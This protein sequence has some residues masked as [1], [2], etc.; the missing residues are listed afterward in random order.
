MTACIADESDSRRCKPCA[1]FW[2]NDGCQSG[3]VLILR[4]KRA[5]RSGS[6]S[7]NTST[8]RYEMIEIPTPGLPVL[9]SLSP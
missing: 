8:S 2:K 5:G 1:F 3:E 9:P 7:V 4:Q 6:F